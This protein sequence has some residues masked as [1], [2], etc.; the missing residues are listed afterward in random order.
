MRQRYRK[1][2]ERERERNPMLSVHHQSFLYSLRL[3]R[4][5]QHQSDTAEGNVFFFFSQS[6]QSTAMLNG[7]VL[8]KSIVLNVFS[9]PSPSRPPRGL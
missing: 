7:K 8:A 3:F 1:K 5:S 9:D 6:V 4:P 2:R